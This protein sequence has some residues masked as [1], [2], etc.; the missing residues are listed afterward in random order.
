MR[1]DCQIDRRSGSRLHLDCQD[2]SQERR[3][4]L[5]KDPATAGIA[6]QFDADIADLDAGSIADPEH[7]PTSGRQPGRF[8]IE[9]HF[10]SR[11]AILQ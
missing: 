6:D 7:K 10:G 1:I 11:V 5:G 4:L 9:S 3:S 2:G 8:W